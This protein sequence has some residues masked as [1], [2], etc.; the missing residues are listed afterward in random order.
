MKARIFS[1]LALWGI[2]IAVLY[3][4]G[5]QGA[6]WLL[7]LVAAL[8]QRELYALWEATGLKP[9]RQAGPWTGALCLLG[10]YYLPAAPGPESAVVTFGLATAGLATTAI[11]KPTIDFLHKTLLPTLAGLW[12]VGFAFY[13][14]LALANAYANWG[15]PRTG[16][17]MA[18]WVIAVAKFTDAG[19][20]LVGKR[21]G[22]TKFAAHI[23]PAKTWEG[24]AGGLLCSAFVGM[25]LVLIFRNSFPPHFTPWL[26]ALIA[27]PVGVAAVLSDL[28]ESV[29]KRMAGVKD[30][31]SNIPGIGGIYDLT[32][33]LLLSAP[34][35]YVLLRCCL[36]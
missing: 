6:A 31:G 28:L 22:K 33:S 21:W 15:M 4:G 2:V 11:R 34:V 25:L 18:I 32:D 23:S 17:F 10:A 26:A 29:F 9:M 20:L 35:A 16:L 30:S 24:V 19:A 1:T 14:L 13:A 12:I 27:L 5:V 3:W 7:A 8:T 36:L